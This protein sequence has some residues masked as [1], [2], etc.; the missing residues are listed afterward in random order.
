MLARLT[1]SWLA[2]RSLARALSPPA[3]IA[4]P[5]DTMKFSP[6]VLDFIDTGGLVS[7]ESRSDKN[8]AELEISASTHL[9]GTSLPR[10]EWSLSSSLNLAA[11]W[12]GRLSGGSMF[13]EPADITINEQLPAN[14]AL[15]D[16]I[17][18]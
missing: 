16:R 4:R 13:L 12:W 18:I 11:C 10:E 7:S 14:F 1:K 15:I 6:V 17:Y 5:T 2:C 9:A 3:S 8:V